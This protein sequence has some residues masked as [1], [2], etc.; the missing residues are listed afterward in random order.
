MRKEQ[1]VHTWGSCQTS[2]ELIS[3]TNI[4]CTPV[5]CAL[6]GVRVSGWRQYC[7]SFGGEREAS[8]IF[9]KGMQGLWRFLYRC[10]KAV[11]TGAIIDES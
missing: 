3:L 4:F 9:N 1:A 8:D 6:F 10:C 11:E 5:P 2:K 7:G